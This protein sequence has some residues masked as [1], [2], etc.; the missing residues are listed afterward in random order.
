MRYLLFTEF[1]ILLLG[2]VMEPAIAQGGEPFCLRLDEK[3]NCRYPSMDACN[4]VAMSGGGYCTENFRLYGNKGAKRYCLATRYG[5]SCVYNDR[6]RC[7]NIAGQRGAEGA[8]CVDNYALSETERRR[9]EEV[10]AS[11]C[12]PSDFAC[13]AGL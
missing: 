7:I 1:L 4:A 13:Q 8:A 6:R 3:E 11:D 12:D 2:P 5:T 10:G 9:L